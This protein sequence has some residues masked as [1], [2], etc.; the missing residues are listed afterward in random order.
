MFRLIIRHKAEGVSGAVIVDDGFVDD[1][2][3]AG[4]E[5]VVAVRPSILLVSRS[6]LW[7]M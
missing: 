5:G 6:Q 4:R 2:C 1:I 3:S 7:R